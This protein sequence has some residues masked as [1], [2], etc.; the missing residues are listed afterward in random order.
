MLKKPSKVAIMIQIE[1]THGRRV[2]RGIIQYAQAYGHWDVYA[3]Q[4]VPIITLDKLEEWQGDGI[5]AN[6]GSEKQLEV[7]KSGSY[8]QKVKLRS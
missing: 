3:N 8:T 1:A 4:G 6:I 7:L 2:M 5:I